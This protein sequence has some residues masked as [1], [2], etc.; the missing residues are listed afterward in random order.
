MDRRVVDALSTPSANAN[1]NNPNNLT[2]TTTATATATTPPTVETNTMPAMHL[3]T[4]TPSNHE[5]P[6][7]SPFEITP[8]DVETLT[9]SGGF[10]ILRDHLAEH[11]NYE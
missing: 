6:H 8:E 4:T 2:A 1:H 3:Q 7:G 9:H 10:A 11:Y 5:L